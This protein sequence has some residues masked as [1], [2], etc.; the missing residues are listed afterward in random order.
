MRMALVA[1]IVTVLTMTGVA[2]CS[3]MESP[4]VT[5]PV[6]MK[7]YYVTGTRTPEVVLLEADW[8]MEA[9]WL[10]NES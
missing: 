4:A 10:E 1:L 2:G 6:T 9:D 3:R 5:R 7:M 8:L